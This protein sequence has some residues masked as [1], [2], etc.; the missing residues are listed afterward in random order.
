[1]HSNNIDYIHVF[2]YQNIDITIV[3]K[4]KIP[5]MSLKSVRKAKA[6][7]FLNWI[8]IL[9]IVVSEEINS[10]NS[11][12]VSVSHGHDRW[13]SEKLNYDVREI[14][15]NYDN[16]CGDKTHQTREVIFWLERIESVFTPLWS[17]HDFGHKFWPKLWLLHSVGITDLF[18]SS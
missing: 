3:D 10:L 8:R 14:H 5:K 7:E 12:G 11:H 17:G 13:F 15:Q 2:E 18:L 4:E 16:I 6:G 1:M 9:L